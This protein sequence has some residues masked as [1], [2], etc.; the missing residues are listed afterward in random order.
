MAT[1]PCCAG[2]AR[3][4]SYEGAQSHLSDGLRPRGFPLVP[5]GC[6]VQQ[7]RL[8]T[9]RLCSGWQV[10]HWEV[11]PGGDG[12]CT[13]EE[14]PGY[15]SR[16]MEPMAPLPAPTEASPPSA[17]PPSPGP[18]RGLPAPSPPSPARPRRSPR[19]CP[20]AASR[21]ASRGSHAGDSGLGAIDPRPVVAAMTP[22][23]GEGGSRPPILA[24]VLRHQSCGSLFGPGPRLGAAGR[25]RSLGLFCCSIRL[26]F[27]CVGS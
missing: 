1:S 14:S 8:Q 3:R 23:P 16:L 5:S 27:T 19:C 9:G 12:V 6:S 18:P 2:T 22:A 17:C 11:P 24:S 15:P 10:L 26:H 20:A 25:G 21:W 4:S 7:E 13:S